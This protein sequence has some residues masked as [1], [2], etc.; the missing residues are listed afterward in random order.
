MSETLPQFV[1]P[2]LRDDLS[3]VQEVLGNE[4]SLLGAARLA[5]EGRTAQV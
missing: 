1:V 2:G 5:F 3:I 4:A